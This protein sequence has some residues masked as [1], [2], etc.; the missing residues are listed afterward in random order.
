MRSDKPTN[1]ILSKIFLLIKKTLFLQIYPLQEGGS[2]QSRERSAGGRERSN[3]F[4]C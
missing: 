4:C 3:D 2:R 1:L